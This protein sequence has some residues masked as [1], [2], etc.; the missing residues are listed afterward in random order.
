MPNSTT[1]T[2]GRGGL[3]FLLSMV[4]TVSIESHKIGVASVGASPHGFLHPS[5]PVGWL[6]LQGN[7]MSS[8]VY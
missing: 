1:Y 2:I 3:S 7:Q 6:D 5:K 8:D 4:T